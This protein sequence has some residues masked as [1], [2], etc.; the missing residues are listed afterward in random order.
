MAQCMPDSAQA[1]TTIFPR[2]SFLPLAT[3]IDNSNTILPSATAPIRL[4]ANSPSAPVVAAGSS[5]TTSKPASG[6]TSSGG[7][8]TAPAVSSSGESSTNGTS[9]SSPVTAIVASLGGAA[10]VAVGVVTVMA[11]R[12]AATKKNDQQN[13]AY[14]SL[15]RPETAMTQMPTL[16]PVGTDPFADIFRLTSPLTASTRPTDSIQYDMGTPIYSDVLSPSAYLSNSGNTMSTFMSIPTQLSR[17]SDA[18]TFMSFPRGSPSLTSDTSS[19]VSMTRLLARYSSS[20]SASTVRDVG[21]RDRRQTQQ[22]VQGLVHQTM[23]RESRLIRFRSN[24][25]IVPPGASWASSTTSSLRSSV[26]SDSTPSLPT[27]AYNNRTWESSPLRMSV[28]STDTDV[29]NNAS[30]KLLVELSHG[31]TRVRETG[32]GHGRAR[33][34]R[35]QDDDLKFSMSSSAAVGLSSAAAALPSTGQYPSQLG[36]GWSMNM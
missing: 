11:R 13:I 1:G 7:V 20:S 26:S 21:D 6:A 15:S 33:S 25:S 2:P 14:L 18:S 3:T 34:V 22:Q 31:D 36:V 4:L 23:S 9:K 8:S 16:Q 17:S 10:V 35:L 12:R 19:R 30:P 24:E 5:Q 32:K 27:L 29:S 28:A